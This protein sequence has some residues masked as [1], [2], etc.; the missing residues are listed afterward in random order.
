[1]PT[2]QTRLSCQLAKWLRL[3]HFE[4]EFSHVYYGL[5]G[6]IQVKPNIQTFASRLTS[7][8]KGSL[9]WPW[10]LSIVRRLRSLTACEVAAVFVGSIKCASRSMHWTDDWILYFYCANQSTHIHTLTHIE[11]IHIH[12]SR[13]RQLLIPRIRFV[14]FPENDAI[15]PLYAEYTYVPNNIGRIIGYLHALFNDPSEKERYRFHVIL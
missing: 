12:R 1:M 13:T 8:P 10:L 5:Q 14:A 9:L 3:T 11:S 6:E 7:S 15:W 2:T 4:C